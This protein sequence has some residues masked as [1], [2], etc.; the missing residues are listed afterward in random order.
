MICHRAAHLA[1]CSH[2]SLLLV[3]CLMDQTFYFL[4]IE[5]HSFPLILYTPFCLNASC[6]H[7][8]T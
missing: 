2:A 4:F 8:R 1:N 6:D 3:K 5:S 7:V